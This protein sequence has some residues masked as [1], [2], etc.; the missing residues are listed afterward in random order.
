MTPNNDNVQTRA[1][2]IKSP[3]LLHVPERTKFGH[4]WP[5]RNVS[6]PGIYAF[7]PSSTV[8]VTLAVNAN[9]EWKACGVTVT[10]GQ[11]LL[12]RLLDTQDAGLDIELYVPGFRN[13]ICDAAEAAV[14]M[15][16]SAWTANS[17]IFGWPSKQITGFSQAVENTE[18]ASERLI[19]VLRDWYDAGVSQGYI[20]QFLSLSSLPPSPSVFCR[21]AAHE[22]T[23][24]KSM[25][26]SLSLSLPLRWRI[27]E[28]DTVRHH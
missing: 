18:T 15:G 7:K 1:G 5:Y 28:S 25:R 23:C 3:W 8:Q 12:D 24:K 27:Y 2:Y 21:I 14:A 13:S 19:Q 4:A 17:Y 11:E 22:W 26:Q 6:M 16:R 9:Q 20:A 10:T